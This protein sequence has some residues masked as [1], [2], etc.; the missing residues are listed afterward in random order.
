MKRLRL[1]AAALAGLFALMPAVAGAIEIK[2]ITTPLGI[3]AWLVEDKSTPV[4]A[5]SFSFSGGTATDPAGQAGITDLMAGL[6]TDGAGSMDAQAFRQR[7]EDAAASLGFNASL[8]RLTGS[9]RVLSANRDEGF[10][11]L[12]LALTE[13]RF[14]P[15]MVAQRRAQ[16]IASIN[17]AAQRPG[18]VAG[19]TLMETLFAG[20]PYAADPDGTPEGLAAATPE[21]LKKR[22]GELLLRNSLIVAAVGDI[23]EAELARQLDRSFGI[24][25]TGTPP[26]LPPQWVPPT[27]PRTVVVERPVPQSS[28]LMALPGIPRDDPDWYAALVLNHVLGGGGQQ[29]RLFNEV[30]E[31][32]GLAYSVS[33]S[34]RTYK[35]AALL[36]MSTGSANER[37][38]EAI[39]VIRAEMRRMRNEGISEAELTDARIYLTGALALSLDSSGSI[40]GLLHS[41]QIDGLS[42]DHLTRRGALIAA[43]KLDDVRKVARRLLRDEALTTV[44]VGKPVGITPE[45]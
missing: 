43:V 9:L 4:V 39:R 22:A 19:R 16:T 30:R 18:S 12:R 14:D 37:V 38:A 3:K 7:Q 35:R 13:P 26:M 6:L 25:P 11:L 40:A 45:P 27:T 17:Q 10:E 1:L 28:A 42:P 5:L 2:E 44:V 23:G 32:R 24:L 31:K 29:S 21:R 36:V 8:D 15:D 41:M 34:L 33:S 20:H